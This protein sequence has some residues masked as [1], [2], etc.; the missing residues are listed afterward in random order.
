ML[1]L[2]VQ[3]DEVILTCF[4]PTWLIVTRPRGESS[5]MQT[6]SNASETHPAVTFVLRQGLLTLGVAIFWGAIFSWGKY[7]E[8]VSFDWFWTVGRSTFCAK[9]R[10][11]AIF[12]SG[13][14]GRRHRSH[15]P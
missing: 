15:G 9:P 7:A 8:T 14:S 4:L 11:S 5:L 12:G 10:T 6:K 1:W 3:P 13:R 2:H